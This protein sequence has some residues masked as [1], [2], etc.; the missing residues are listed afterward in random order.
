[1]PTW[2]INSLPV[3]TL[4]AAIGGP[5]VAYVIGARTVRTALTTA[6]AQVRT[7][8][9]V[10]RLQVRSSVVS[11][12][13]QKWI[14]ALRDELAEFL[15]ERDLLTTKLQDPAPDSVS[16]RTSSSRLIRLFHQLQL[17]L[18]PKEEDHARIMELT[19]QL[20]GRPTGSLDDGMIEELVKLSQTVLKREWDRVKSGD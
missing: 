12:N 9:E 19:S 6:Q 2:L 10:A 15:A 4:A 14:D 17:R 18:N 7:A 20:A 16:V 5:L 13:R 8:L 1:M 11:S 3:L